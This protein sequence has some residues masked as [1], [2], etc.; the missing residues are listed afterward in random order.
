MATKKKK[1][2]LTAEEEARLLRDIDFAVCVEPTQLCNWA[3][4]AAWVTAQVAGGNMDLAALYWIRVFGLMDEVRGE[5]AESL[6]NRDRAKAEGV[7]LTRSWASRVWDAKEAVVRAVDGLK[8]LFS[9]DELRYF[10][11]RRDTE[12][13]PVQDHYRVQ[14]RKN[15]LTDVGAKLLGGERLSVEE[16]RAA[17]RRVIQ[18]YPSEVAIAVAWAQRSVTHV[19]AVAK[20]LRAW[21]NL[22]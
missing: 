20:A 12:S 13:H 9:E 6:A 4:N 14:V 8:A 16:T 1:R 18:A 7:D 15:G 10:Q 21:M 19:E 22:G 17:H 5:M 11:Y 3:D 2:D